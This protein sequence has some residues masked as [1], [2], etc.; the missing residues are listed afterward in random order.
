MSYDEMTLRLRC[1]VN[2]RAR[3]D[4]VP[5]RMT[6]ADYLR[7]VLG[8]TGTHLGCE[9]GACGACTVRA[10]GKVVRA[11]LMLAVQAEGMCIDTI[12]GLTASGEL[13]DL[14]DAFHRHAAL[15]CGFC[16]A[17]MLITADDALRKEPSISRDGVRR[18]LTGNLCRCTGYQAIVDAVVDTARMRRHA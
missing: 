14:Q 3:A 12:E 5:V 8:L 1:T 6:L 9:Q 4:D 10:D 18:A 16:T 2:G 11:C 15:Q 13:A 17:G 7:E